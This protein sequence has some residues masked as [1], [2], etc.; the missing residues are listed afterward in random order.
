M[1]MGIFAFL[2]YNVAGIKEHGVSYVKQFMGP[3]LVLAPLFIV[4]ESISHAARPLSLS[5]RL[6]ANIFGDHL[7]L[8]VFAGMVPLIVPA[9]LLFF[10]LLVAFIQSFVFTVL[11]GIYINL[12]I[13]HDH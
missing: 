12:A 1:A 11:T 6:T 5:F 3:F 2:V 4:L 8:G 13:S 7:L 10:G 9:L